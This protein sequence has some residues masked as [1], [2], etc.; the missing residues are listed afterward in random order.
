[1]ANCVRKDDLHQPAPYG[2]VEPAPRALHPGCAKRADIGYKLARVP[3]RLVG[4][5]GARARRGLV[6]DDDPSGGGIGH[7][8]RAWA[9]RSVCVATRFRP[10]AMGFSSRTTTEPTAALPSAAPVRASSIAICMNR[11]CAFVITVSVRCCVILSLSLL[12]DA[13][14]E[15]L[16]RSASR[17]ARACAP[18]HRG[19]RATTTPPTAP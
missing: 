3:D 11:S 4:P 19:G 13:V 7:R 6:V 17:S 16:D 5:F 12:E 14:H 8:R 10:R 18:R 1:M 15:R 9:A 2:K